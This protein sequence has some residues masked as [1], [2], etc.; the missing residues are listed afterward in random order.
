MVKRIPAIWRRWSL[1][2]LPLGGRGLCVGR[3]G[4]IGADDKACPG[5]SPLDR[6]LAVALRTAA[7]DS[8]PLDVIRNLSLEEKKIA[9]EG[10]AKC[11][12]YQQGVPVFDVERQRAF[13]SATRAASHNDMLDG[14]AEEFI[15]R[16]RDL[17]LA[18][19][20]DLRASAAAIVA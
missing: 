4:D 7:G 20:Q 2:A 11:R 15:T 6:L 1:V 10:V 18:I 12:S 19:Y 3:C 14:L 17:T 5:A 13:L 9:F 8:V 16:H